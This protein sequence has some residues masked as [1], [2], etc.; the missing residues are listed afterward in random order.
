MS[1]RQCPFCGR[2]EP[3][4]IEEVGFNC[5]PHWFYRCIRCLAQ[6]PQTVKSAINALKLW[7]GDV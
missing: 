3:E 5:V 7:D 6:G 2:H 4:L 1:P